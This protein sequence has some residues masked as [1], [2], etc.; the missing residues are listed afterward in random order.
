MVFILNK[1]LTLALAKY[2]YKD[3]QCSRDN[4]F[5]R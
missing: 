3:N 5:E 4:G 2:R 1:K